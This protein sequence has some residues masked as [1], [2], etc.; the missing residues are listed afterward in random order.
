VAD[1]AVMVDLNDS[2]TFT[3]ENGITFKKNQ[4]L[5]WL[6]TYPV[7]I[8]QRLAGHEISSFIR[9]YDLC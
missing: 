4:Q 7:L 3:H 5:A 2:L 8:A 9:I 1:P 6:K